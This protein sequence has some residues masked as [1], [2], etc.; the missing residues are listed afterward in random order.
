[1]KDEYPMD[2]L[3]P[4][5]VAVNK[6]IELYKKT[7][8]KYPFEMTY[9]DGLGKCY[10]DL[11]DDKNAEATYRKSIEVKEKYRGPHGRWTDQSRRKRS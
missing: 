8:A 2:S 7:I 11:G 1:M 5:R 10:L 3:K 6:A 9:Y 4:N